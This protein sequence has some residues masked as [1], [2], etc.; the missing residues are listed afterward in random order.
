[1]VEF[2]VG[3]LREGFLGLV[4]LFSLDQGKMAAQNLT[5]EPGEAKAL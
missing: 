4:K 3:S 5:S 2:D 1:M